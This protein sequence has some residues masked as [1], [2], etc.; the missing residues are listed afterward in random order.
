MKYEWLSR[1]SNAGKYLI[2]AYPISSWFIK[3]SASENGEEEYYY[4]SWL[5]KIN[6]LPSLE[7]IEQS[8]LHIDD[9]Y[10]KTDTDVIAPWNIQ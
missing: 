2:K 8:P 6:L 9:L 4:V 7:E 3:E 1:S 10:Y 5:D